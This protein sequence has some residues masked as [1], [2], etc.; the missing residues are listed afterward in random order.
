MLNSRN[1]FI[2]I[3]SRSAVAGVGF[4]AGRDLYR[5]L[6]KNWIVILA[7][8]VFA[9]GPGYLARMASE[10]HDPRSGFERFLKVWLPASSLAAYVVLMASATAA[11]ASAPDGGGYLPLLLIVTLASAGIG[12]LLGLGRRRKRLHGFEIARANE[13]FLADA[14]ISELGGRDNALRDP[15]GNELVLDDRRANE[16]V[17]KVMG[18]RGKRAYITHDDKG[19]FIQ[20]IPIQEA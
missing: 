14:G 17:F 6:K 4:G 20:Y 18:R 15:W 5:G 13:R 8:C 19:R 9:L 12:L 7:V 1:D 10:G 2:R 3:I 16:I 11:K